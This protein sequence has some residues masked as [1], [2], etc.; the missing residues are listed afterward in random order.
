M[1]SSGKEESLLEVGCSKPA[2]GKRDPAIADKEAV[3]GPGRQ[4]GHRKLARGET[5]EKRWQQGLTRSEQIGELAQD[6]STMRRRGQLWWRRGRN[7]KGR[8][9]GFVTMISGA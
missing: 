9:V 6:C 7:L 5:P 8:V 3:A 4:S 1:D 2:Y